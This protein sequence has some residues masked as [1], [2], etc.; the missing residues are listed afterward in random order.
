MSSHRNI[1][2]KLMAELRHE[3]NRMNR[4]ADGLEAAFDQAM[5]NRVSVEDREPLCVAAARAR[6][7]AQ[8]IAAEADALY[9][10]LEMIKKGSRASDVGT[11]SDAREAANILL[12]PPIL[13]ERERKLLG[14]LRDNAHSG[15]A[16]M[17]F[18]DLVRMASLSAEDARDGMAT[19]CM[20]GMI[21][22]LI[23]GRGSAPSQWRILKT[24]FGGVTAPPISPKVA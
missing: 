4:V 12:N 23:T 9:W 20:A 2:E 22:P 17:F 21:E 18:T 8:K 15:I 5:V 1:A 6:A 7:D 3:A 13:R 19:L 14:I 10:L 16:K 24:G 11:H